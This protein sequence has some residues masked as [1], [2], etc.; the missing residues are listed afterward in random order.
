LIESIKKGEKENS[1][2][3]KI[4]SDAMEKM[5]LD[6]DLRKQYS[7]GIE[8]AKAVFDVELVLDEWEALIQTE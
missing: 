7:N 5:L 8:R 3:E 1:E 4:F 2:K 6:D